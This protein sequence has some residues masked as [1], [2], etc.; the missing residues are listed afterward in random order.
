MTAL[1]IVGEDFELGLVVGL[2]FVRDRQIGKTK[3]FAI[4]PMFEEDAVAA[5]LPEA[6]RPDLASDLRS[7]VRK[8]LAEYDNARKDLERRKDGRFSAW[9]R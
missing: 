6:A 4:E 2:G 5:L 8:A 7:L 1:H 3:R 9:S